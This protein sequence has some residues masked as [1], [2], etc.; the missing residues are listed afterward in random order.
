MGFHM[1]FP[2]DNSGVCYHADTL[3][4]FEALLAR[5]G[6]QTPKMETVTAVCEQC[7][8]TTKGRRTRTYEGS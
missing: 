1:R 4:E 2:S 6:I 5:F 3:D 7:G 8:H